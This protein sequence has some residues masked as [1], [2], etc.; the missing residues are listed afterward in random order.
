MRLIEWVVVWLI[1]TID[2][3]RA[4]SNR[5]GTLREQTG[6]SAEAIEAFRRQVESD[7]N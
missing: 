1:E 5:L 6:I 4:A 3:T 2:G 7:A